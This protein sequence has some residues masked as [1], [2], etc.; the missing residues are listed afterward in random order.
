MCVW[1]PLQQPEGLSLAFITPNYLN[2]L[3]FG[4]AVACHGTIRSFLA[5]V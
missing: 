2:M 3:V 1:I 5:N 4:L